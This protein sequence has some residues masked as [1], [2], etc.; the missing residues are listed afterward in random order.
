MP[1]LTGT[2]ETKNASKYLQQLCKHFGHKID[3]TF[4][5][6]SA[7]CVFVFGTANMTAEETSLRIDFEL[8]EVE[9]VAAAKSVIDRHLEKFAFREAFV[10]M[11]WVTECQ[12]AS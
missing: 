4:D 12:N 8:S 1:R 9:A 3:V 2:Y 11:D 10:S 6:F 7:Q 5:C